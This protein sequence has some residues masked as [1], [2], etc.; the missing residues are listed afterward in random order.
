MARFMIR[1]VAAML[2]ALLLS[3][4][5]AFGTAQNTVVSGNIAY[6]FFKQRATDDVVDLLHYTGNGGNERKTLA[7]M[8]AWGKD[9]VLTNDLATVGFYLSDFDYFFHADNDGDFET[10]A[11]DTHNNSRCLVMHRNANPW[12]DRH[13]WTFRE[14]AD[15][16]C[17]PGSSYV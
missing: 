2:S 3:S 10:A 7:A 11:S 14:D 17:I 13:N 9:D 8:L 12:G 1:I 16:Y 5:W 4:C 6:F 15:G